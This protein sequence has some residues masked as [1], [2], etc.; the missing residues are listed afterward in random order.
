MQPNCRLSDVLPLRFANGEQVRQ[1]S[2]PCLSCGTMLSAQHMIGVARV[3]ND[4]I[5]IAA[6]AQCP[7]CGER[8]SVTCMIDDEKRVRRVVLPYWLFNPYLRMLKPPVKEGAAREVRPVE[9]L[10]RPDF[11]GA[12]QPGPVA[13]PAQKLDIVRADDAVGSYQGKPIPA[14]VQVNGKQFSFER[15]AIDMRAGEGEV[16]IDGCLVYRKQ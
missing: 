1:F 16:L 5:A 12:E 11:M 13:A 9:E 3:V 8:F 10:P 4:H 15:I 14:W 6:R 7:S 2:K